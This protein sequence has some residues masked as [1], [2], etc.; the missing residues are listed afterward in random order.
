MAR[1]EVDGGRKLRRFLYA[2]K[3]RAPLPL[4]LSPGPKKRIYEISYSYTPARTYESF[5]LCAAGH[6]VGILPTIP[7]ETD[8]RTARS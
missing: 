6:L 8:K 7:Y 4:S 1:K 3:Y 2:Q 5:S